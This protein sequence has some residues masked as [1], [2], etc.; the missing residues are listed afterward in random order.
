MHRIWFFPY[1]V[2]FIL[3]ILAEPWVKPRRTEER[4]ARCG[5]ISLQLLSFP[6]LASGLATGFLLWRGS[7]AHPSLYFTGL[8]LFVLGF[9]GRAA[10]LRKLGR[11]YSLYIDPAPTEALRT[12]GIY[13][14]VRHPVYACYLVETL[15]LLLI[16]PNIVSLAALALVALATAWRIREEERALLAR[17]GEEYRRYMAQ[18][19]RLLPW[20]Y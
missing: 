3:R 6:F 19:H 12:H 14:L 5:K 7:P 20:V 1:A 15:A 17:Y 16:R 13:G 8:I 9:A 18:T 11:G 10:A 4:P 2:L